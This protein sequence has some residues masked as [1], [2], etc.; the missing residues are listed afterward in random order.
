MIRQNQKYLS[1]ALVLIDAISIILALVLSWIIRFK[2]GFI[3]INDGYLT[4]EQ[5][6]F[7][8]IFIIPLYLFIYSIFSLYTT[9]RVRKPFEELISITRSNVVGILIFILALYLFKVVDYSRYLI[10]IFG[11]LCI[12]F[13]FIERFV[14]RL[15]L[16]RLRKNGY[17]LKH[18][19]IIGLSEI[20]YELMSKLVFNS[21]WGYNIIGILDDNIEA[22]N[23]N[24]NNL[25]AE[26]NNFYGN[27]YEE[28]AATLEHYKDTKILGKIDS[29]QSFLNEFNVDEIFITLDLKEYFKIG[30]II[31]VCEKM[32]IRVQI[33]P[34]YYKYIPSRPYLE[35]MDGLP[36]IN[37]RYVPLDNFLNNFIKRAFD[38]VFSI[39]SIILFLPIM[40]V[41]SLIMKL[42]SPGPIIFKQERVGLNRKPFTMYKFRSM[43]VQRTEDEV[44]KWTTK[45]DSR[46]TKFGSFIRKIS[47]DELLQLFNVLKGDMS[48]IGPRPERPFYVDKFKEEI[49]K[50]MIK[51]HV[52]PG[53]TGWAQVNGWRGDTSI[54]KRIEYDI[55]YIENW[56][57]TIDMK[58]LFLTIFNG[59]I[60]KNAY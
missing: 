11:I 24:V 6:L 30:S 3:N 4:F 26:L 13:T 10:F 49:P 57:I 44:N 42:T 15:I 7:P 16:K 43:K 35:D 37:L 28:V 40:I 52:R 59:F 20:T 60:N 29:L 54:H 41:T 56:S 53:M 51:H 12:T 50:Y 9:Q 46:K 14:M 45:E 31:G 48:L 38:I 18:I 22:E 58:I 23:L 27:T 47:I 55:Y 25:K 8:L 2:S 39:L 33:I 34:G 17:N 5:Y 1:K 36:M 21:H 19:L 32:G